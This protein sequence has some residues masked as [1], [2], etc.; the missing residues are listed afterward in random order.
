MDYF[1]DEPL[2]HS[3]TEMDIKFP[4]ISN[5]PREQIKKEAGDVR[6]LFRRTSALFGNGRGNLIALIIAP[7]AYL[8]RCLVTRTSSALVSACLPSRGPPLRLTKSQISHF[9]FAPFVLNLSCHFCR[10]LRTTL[11]FVRILTMFYY[12]LRLLATFVLS[13]ILKISLH[14]V[15]ETCNENNLWHCTHLHLHAETTVKLYFRW[16]FIIIVRYSDCSRDGLRKNNWIGGI[17]I[18]F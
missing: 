15:A 1:N 17:I 7:G 3:G 10:M 16:K 14:A 6:E 9:V 8:R 13:N 11:I 4:W 5:Q 12:I 2:A 18:S